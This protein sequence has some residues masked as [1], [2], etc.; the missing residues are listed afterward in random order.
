[1]V[2]GRRLQKLREE[3]KLSQGDIESKTSLLRCYTSRVE[4][5]KTVP[6]VET[7]E[8]YAAALN[9]PL[10]KLFY[11]GSEPPEVLKLPASKIKQWNACREGAYD[12]PH[13]S[14]LLARMSERDRKLLLA[15]ALRM[16]NRH[17]QDRHT[18]RR[19]NLG[20]SADSQRHGRKSS[21]VRN[22]R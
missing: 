4:N 11:D 2:V 7:L 1:V 5:G 20:V 22:G 12:L 9:L 15:V 8:K 13:L 19:P 6:S 3:R 18:R 21:E 10:Y 16:S 14:H 17:H